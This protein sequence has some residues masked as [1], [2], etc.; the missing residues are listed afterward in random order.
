MDITSRMHITRG[1]GITGLFVVPGGKGAGWSLVITRITGQTNIIPPGRIV[2]ATG[3]IGL[4]VEAKL[5]A[6][7][8]RL[9]AR[10]RRHVLIHSCNDLFCQAA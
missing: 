3:E 6:A 4:A 9:T 5:R 2:I 1:M 8:G 7:S 10:R